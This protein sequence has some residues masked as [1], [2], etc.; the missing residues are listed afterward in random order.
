MTI[1]SGISVEE[2]ILQVLQ[3]LGMQ[4]AHFAASRPADWRG[5]V[6]GHPEV[7]ASL[8]LVTP[9]AI[10]S[11]V[12]GTLAPR[13]LVFNGDRGDS[14]E[15]LNR[16]MV[17][18]P[19]ATLVAL[20]DYERSN[21]ADVIAD[22]GDSIGPAM[23]N[24]LG[25]MNQ[26]QE[27]SAVSLSEG[28]GEVAG[29]SYR[30][31]GSGPPLVLLPIERASSQ[32]ESLLPVLAHHYSTII[33]GGAWLGFIATMEARAKGGYL[34][35][36]GRMVDETRLQPGERVLDVGCGPGTLDRWLAHR[37][38]GANPI[39]GMDISPYLTREAGALA[40]SEGL[41]GVIE[42]REGS[43]EALPF[44]DNSFDVSMS[45]TVIQLVDANQMLAEMVRVTKP[46]GRVGVVGRG[47]D[48]PNMINL[49]VRAELRAK[50]EAQR[51]QE[52][53]NPQGCDDA[54]LYRRF[55]QAG[56][57]EVKMFPQLAVYTDRT[58]LQFMNQNQIFPVLDPEE[59]EEWRA[60]P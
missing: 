46:G 51:D 39:V 30:V 35:T 23:I 1:E 8:T 44:P 41:D 52:P 21:L 47:D 12:L 55:H 54:S 38:G 33:L 48:R 59:M 43:A 57:T 9:S 18:L 58:R 60:A 32:W 31:R 45:F 37:T 49:P 15:T 14:A 2:R 7:I 40:R 19:D 42:F 50:A 26:G 24:F 13:L 28:E 56:L 36:V 22:R 11:G 6:T 34:E 53:H 4:Q 10:D 27:A 3:H 29:V 17:S 5:L 20:Q 16:S 25:R